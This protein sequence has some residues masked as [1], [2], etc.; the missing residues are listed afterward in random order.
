MTSEL[1]YLL[2]KVWADESTS[3]IGIN[4]RYTQF[5][6]KDHRLC[7]ESCSGILLLFKSYE[8]L[9]KIVGRVFS[10]RENFDKENQ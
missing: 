2:N 7:C 10:D 4:V 3:G 9:S 8:V 6:N 1:H 5:I